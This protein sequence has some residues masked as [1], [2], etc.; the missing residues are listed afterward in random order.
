MARDTPHVPRGVPLADLIAM[1]QHYVTFYSPGT[2][3]AETNTEKVDAWDV[4]AAIERARSVLH[5]YNAMPYGFRFTTRGR[6]SDDL[7]AKEISQSPMYYLGGAVETLA[8]V[9]ARDNP[10]DRILISNMDGNGYD[11]I[12]TNNNS[13]KWTQPLRPDDVVLEFTA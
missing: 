9:K 7:D 12:I 1:E 13:W 8:E 3:F 10:G 2:F 4:D 11:R 5:R 6:G